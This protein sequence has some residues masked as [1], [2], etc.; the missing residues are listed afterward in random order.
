MAIA[1]ALMLSTPAHAA[2]IIVNSLADTG[3]PGIC[4]LRDAITTANDKTTT[5]SCIAG[6][7]SDTIRFSVTGTIALETTLREI[8]DANLTIVG[9]ASPGIK[10]DGGG[11]VQL[12]VVASGA[13]VNLSH[14]AIANGAGSGFLGAGGVENDG[15]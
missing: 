3:A 5:N 12:M 8:T 11:K 15:T 13:T 10:I 7:G 2:A 1:F 6:T 9:P 4:V 14:L